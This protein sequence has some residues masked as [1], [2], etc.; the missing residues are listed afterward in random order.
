MLGEPL[1]KAGANSEAERKSGTTRMSGHSVQ[2]ENK[3]K[4][5][6]WLARSPRTLFFKFTTSMTL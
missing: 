1:P 5:G 3:L 6:Q 4:R 2:A